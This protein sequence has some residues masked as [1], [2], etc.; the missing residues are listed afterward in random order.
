MNRILQ[1]ITGIVFLSGT[2]TAQQLIF[3]IE[4]QRSV[5]ASVDIYSPVEQSDAQSEVAP[6]MDLWVQAVE[7]A[8]SDSGEFSFTASADQYSDIAA[9]SLTAYGT[10][11][12]LAESWGPTLGGG[13]VAENRC[14]VRF[15]VAE[16]VAYVLSGS[17]ATYADH[18]SAWCCDWFVESRITVELDQVAGPTAA[19][20]QSIV[21]LDWSQQGDVGDS[22]PVDSVGELEPGVYEL[23]IVATITMPQA[24]LDSYD[25]PFNV[26]GEASFIVALDTTPAGPGPIC[27]AVDTDTDG[28]VDLEDYCR[29]QTCFTGPGF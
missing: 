25:F 11:D 23:E 21:T 16:P 17:L 28:D 7:A 12:I 4:Q 27:E 3:P 6:D 8:V 9:S 26:L 1:I 22:R 24:V 13:G 15:A 20:E 18:T 10:A 19:T 14:R 5:Q 29:F 2:A